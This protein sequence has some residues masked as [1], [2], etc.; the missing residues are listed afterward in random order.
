MS[1][2]IEATRD[3]SELILELIAEHKDISL[4]FSTRYGPMLLCL[5]RG[6]LVPGAHD[7]VVGQYCGVPLYM[8]REQAERWRGRR[9]TIVRVKGV[10]PGFSIDSPSGTHF[11]LRTEALTGIVE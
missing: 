6:E 1:A 7:V 4:H 11:E 3:A 9:M 8:T 5:P 10:A 2:P